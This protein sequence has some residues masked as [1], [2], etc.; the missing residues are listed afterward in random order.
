MRRLPGFFKRNLQTAPQ[1][2]ETGVQLANNVALKRLF[3]RSRRRKVWH[4]LRK[5]EP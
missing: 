1:A 2:V 4:K 5:Q 3:L